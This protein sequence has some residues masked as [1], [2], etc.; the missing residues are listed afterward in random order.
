MTVYQRKARQISKSMLEAHIFP[1]KNTGT[2]ILTVRRN[3]NIKIHADFPLSRK[4]S[5]LQFV[6]FILE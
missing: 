6:Y 5:W 3:L 1:Q 2:N 4:I